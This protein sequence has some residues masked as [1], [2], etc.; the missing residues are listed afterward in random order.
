MGVRG[1]VRACDDSASTC[2]S[3]CSVGCSLFFTIHHFLGSCLQYYHVTIFFHD[4]SLVLHIFNTVC[5]SM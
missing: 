5:I 1:N 4:I 2:S 3:K